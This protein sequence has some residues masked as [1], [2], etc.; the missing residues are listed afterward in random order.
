[1]ITVLH[2]TPHLGGG[3]GK[4]LSGLIGQA[5]LSGAPIRHVVV[6]LEAPQKSQFLD[7]IRDSGCEVIV[8][9]DLARLNELVSLA[10]IVQLE[11]WNHPATIEA[12]CR[13]ASQPMR[14]LVW[15][16][17][18]GLYSPII[19]PK[20][21]EASGRFLFTSPCSFEAIEVSGIAGRMGNRLSVVSSGGGFEGFPRIKEDDKA[22]ISVGYLGSLN[23]AKLHPNYVD[24]LSAVNLPDFKVRLIGDLLNRELLQVQSNDAGRPGMLDFRGYTTDV[25]GELSAINVLAYLLNPRHYGTAENALLEAMAMGIVPVV[26]DNPAERSIVE[27]LS[28]GLIV[29]SPSEFADAL[30]WLANN[31]LNRSRIG[32]QAA[33]MVRE[34]YIPERTEAA[35]R[36][37]YEEVLRE[38][39]RPVPFLNIFG[40][41]PSDWFLSC[42]GAPEIFELGGGVRLPNGGLPNFDLLEKTKGSAFHFHQYFPENASLAGWAANLEILSERPSNS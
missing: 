1:L 7:R 42:Q 4:A 26:L 36:G 18:S 24:F 16:H 10:D 3:V 15:C 41:A 11:W 27:H 32:M 35:F 23:F 9:P 28:T 29:R 31:P 19:P 5:C 33:A 20:L 12:L 22:P 30:A 40:I 25:A 6:C 34:R 38:D 8:A 2:L 37:H 17:V 14:L 21:M 39:K 13:M